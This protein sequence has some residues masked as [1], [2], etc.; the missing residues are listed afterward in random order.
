MGP[1]PRNPLDR[2]MEKIDKAS[3]PRGCWLWTA[4]KSHNGYGFFKESPRQMTKAHRFAYAQWVAPIPDGLL[5]CHHCDTPACVNPEHLYVGTQ[6][7]NRGDAVDRGRTATGLRS[8]MHTHPE[9][10]QYGKRADT[11]AWLRGEQ[12]SLS[13]VTEQDVREIR[14]LRSEGIRNDELALRYG[15]DRHTITSI[16]SGRTWKHVL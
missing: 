3:S 11:S 12:V 5:V 1:A 14:R 10:R 16:T 15:V 6:K 4:A 7:Q 2:F 8:G 9:A 13:K